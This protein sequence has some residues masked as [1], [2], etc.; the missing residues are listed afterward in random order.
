M[1]YGNTN[2]L[3]VDLFNFMFHTMKKFLLV[4]IAAVFIIGMLISCNKS[5]CPAYVM[6]NEIEQVENNS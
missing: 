6:E 3:Q 2:L 5:V 4:V 1:A